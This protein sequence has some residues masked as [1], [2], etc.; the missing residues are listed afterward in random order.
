MSKKRT[1]DIMNNIQSFYLENKNLR[2]RLTNYGAIIQE[3]WIL[4]K[5]GIARNIV[6]GHKNPIDYFND[7]TYLGACIGR[8]A[9]RLSGGLSI[10]KVYHPLTSENGVHLHGGKEGF[11]KKI[12]IIK[13]ITK[14]SATFTIFSPDGDEGYPGNLWVEA[15]YK[16]I[17]NRLFVVYSASTDSTTCVNLTNHTYFNLHPY[18]NIN[19]QFLKINADH[20]LELNNDLLPT[21]SVCSVKNSNV[22]FK[23]HEK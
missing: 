20:F 14:A 6:L 19:S 15:S 2:V 18:N 8:Y 5:K 4:D 1:T 16:I 9:G 21:G 13:Q 17:K 3:I 10:N 23:K 7:D 11:N 22:N 12:W